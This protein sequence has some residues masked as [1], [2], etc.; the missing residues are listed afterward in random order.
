[1]LF[2]LVYKNM[3][4]KDVIVYSLSII[5]SVILW[6]IVLSVYRINIQNHLGEKAGGINTLCL[7][8]LLWLLLCHFFFWY[9]PHVF[10]SNLKIR[11]IV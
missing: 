7:F 4:F 5:F 3:N 10:L 9:M 2:K 8:S 6:V 11:I 1:M